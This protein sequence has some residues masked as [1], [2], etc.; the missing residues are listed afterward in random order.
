MKIR[1]VSITATN[2]DA[3]A[4]FYRDVLRLPVDASPHRVRVDIGTSRL[5]ITPGEAFAGVHH[6]AF[7]ISPHDFETAQRWLRP[8]F[9]LLRANGSDIIEAP[10][11]WDAR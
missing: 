1:E 8:R 9:D 11:G 6:L 10:A 3:A 2:L 7:G 4:D 5:V